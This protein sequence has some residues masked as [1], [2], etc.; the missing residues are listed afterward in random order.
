MAGDNITDADPEILS[1]FISETLEHLQNSEAC[2]LKLE[3]EPNN[4]ENLNSVFRAFHS[5]KGTSSFLGLGRIKDLAHHAEML[6][7]RSRKGEIARGN[8]FN[9]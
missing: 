1:E 3:T 8:T 4:Q 6:L 2:L 7:D 5:T 9:R